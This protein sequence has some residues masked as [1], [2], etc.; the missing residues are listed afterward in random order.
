MSRSRIAGVI[1]TAALIVALAGCASADDGKTEVVIWDPGLLN[2]IASD[3]TVEPK[4]AF[5]DAAVEEYEAQHPDI[6]I[7][8][9]ETP[10]DITTTT[11]QFQA[12]S[13]AGNG[14]DLK[15]GYTGGGTDSFAQ[16][17]VDLDDVLSDDIKNDLTGWDA[18]RQGYTS[19]GKLLAL[20]FG[21]GAYFYVFYNKT[22]AQEAGIDI[23]TAS[24]SWEALIAAAEQAKDAGQIPFWMGNQ[25]G[26]V[27]AWLLAA[28]A[29]GELGGAAFTD[30]YSGETQIDSPAML[31]AYQA[32]A[33][34]FAQGLTNPDAG[35]LTNGDS[36]TGFLA[37]DGLFYI[38]GAWMNQTFF[39]TLGDDVGWFP[40]P[41]FEDAAYPDAIAGGPNEAISLTTYAKEPEAA[42]DFLEFLGQSSTID[43]FVE[44]NQSEASNSLTADTSVITNPLLQAQADLLATSETRT[45]PFDNVMPQSVIDL[46]YKVNATTFLGTTTPAD[47]L[48]QLQA[49]FD[50]AIAD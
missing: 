26:Y 42:A 16:Y 5:L 30:M 3:G 41:M 33:D 44:M 50:T 13:I 19:D 4:T 38:S 27:G 21:A 24:E 47:A 49:E 32:Y 22:L 40:I 43:L 45:F 11:A 7:K 2:K 12:A 17:F 39:D 36:A 46:F 34:L 15:V 10:T 18:V 23:A 29:G 9:V 14:P 6:R 37:G 25:E 1:T 20:P 48:A 28:L 8:V 31:K 35:S